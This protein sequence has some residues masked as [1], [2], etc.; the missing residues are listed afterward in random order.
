MR[1]IKLITLAVGISLLFSACVIS[2]AKSGSKKDVLTNRLGYVLPKYNFSIDAAYDPRTAGIIEGYTALT[3]AVVNKGFGAVTMRPDKDSW[4]IKDR[5]GSWHRGILDI[6]Y[7]APEQWHRLHPKAKQL[8]IYPTAIP[9]GYT[10]TFQLFF[11]GQVD[12]AGFDRIRYHS[13]DKKKT[14]TFTRY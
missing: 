6:Q 1:V 7:E 2:G 8:M 5:G 10:Q 13:G 9:P 12:L 14:F 11:P 4:K 3:V